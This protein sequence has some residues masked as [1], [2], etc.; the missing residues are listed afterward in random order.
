MCCM[1]GTR[2]G[3]HVGRHCDRVDCAPEACNCCW[4]PELMQAYDITD[5]KLSLLIRCSKD[6]KHNLTAHPCGGSGPGAGYMQQEVLQM[7]EP[8]FRK[9]AT[10]VPDNR[11]VPWGL[12]AG[13][14]MRVPQAKVCI[15]T[16]LAGMS[17]KASCAHGAGAAARCSACMRSSPRQC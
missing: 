8:Q 14:G 9:A 16:K 1:P 15:I 5:L 17:R 12:V 4:L 2:L 7:G 6:A 10:G 3:I 13:C 11:A